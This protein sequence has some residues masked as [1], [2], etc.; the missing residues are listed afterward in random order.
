MFRLK[1]ALFAAA[2]LASPQVAS[3]YESLPRQL[4]SLSPQDFADTVVVD[5]DPLKPVVMLSTQPGYT[6]GR[7]IEGAYAQDVHLRAVVDRNTGSV[8]WQVWHD[9]VN[10]R[11]HKNVVAVHYQQA[12]SMAAADPLAVDRWLDEC[13]PTDGIGS[14]N[15]FTRV[16]FE[17]PE[18]VVRDVAA[19]YRAG[20]R[21]PWRLHFKDVSGRDVTGGIAPAEAAGL[22]QALDS[23]RNS[24][25]RRMN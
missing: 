19:S 9:L 20:S 5:D 12:G 22:V 16:A 1:P 24:K 8:K 21:E 11:G 15:Q 18:D 7:S 6:R 10:V 14:C 17:L 4:A 23:W 2:L 25:T 13:P 3:A